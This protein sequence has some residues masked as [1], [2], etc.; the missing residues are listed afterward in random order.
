MTDCIR[1]L[2]I[3]S[4]YLKEIFILS[5]ITFNYQTYLEIEKIYLNMILD[6]M[7][8]SF[9]WLQLINKLLMQSVTLILFFFATIYILYNIQLKCALIPKKI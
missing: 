6:K 5:N 7:K 8:S 4:S 1:S 2:L 9:K 3:N